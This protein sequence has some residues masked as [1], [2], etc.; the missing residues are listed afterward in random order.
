M[1]LPGESSAHQAWTDPE[2]RQT[3]RT[4]A[5][6]AHETGQADTASVDVLRRSGLLGMTVSTDHGGWG[7][8][9]AA[10]NTVIEGVAVDNPSIAIML[11]LHCA[12]VAR[13]ET[14][15]TEEQKKHW[16][17]RVARHGQ[18]A[19]SA[20]SEPGSSADKRS[21]STDARRDDTAAWRIKGGKTFSTSATVADFFLVLV[22]LPATCETAHT[23]EPAYGGSDQALFLV[24]ADAPGVHVPP[25]PLD[26]AGMRGS[27]TGMVQFQ[28]VTVTDR[29][30]LCSGGATTEAIQ[31]PHRLGLTLGAVSVG[32]AQ[33]A[34]DT[35]LR[36]ARDRGLLEDGRFRQQLALTEV[37]VRSARAAVGELTAGPAHDRVL[38]AYCVKVSTSTT[39]Q[40][41]C[42]TVRGFLGSSGYLHAHEINRISQD[43]DAVMHMGPPTHLCL[44][45][46]ATRLSSARPSGA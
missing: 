4:G 36:H 18:L 12:V 45:L 19:A 7:W 20:W 8:D 38:R 2:F 24:D 31:L 23:A 42:G 39:S 37:A 11:Y 21:L 41:V 34:S 27:A 9:A 6:R 40:T 43:A 13:I 46:I 30:M 35:A 25:A 14:Y 3:L 29:D 33:A 16:L 17:P 32:L 26:M 5:R 1:N 15:G 44:D 10:A 28:D 22:Q